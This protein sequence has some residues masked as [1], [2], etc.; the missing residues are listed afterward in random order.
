MYNVLLVDDEPIVKIAL[1]TMIH[2]DELGF[3][4]CG[5]A[6][7]GQEALNLVGKLKP[8]IIITDLKMPN[9][10]GLQF[11]RELNAQNYKGKVIVASN[12]GDYELVREA[13][14]LGAVDYILKIS[15]QTEGLITQ[16]RQTASLL[17]EEQHTLQE[18]EAKDRFLRN[19]LKSVKSS[20]L[21]DYFT[22]THYDIHHF[23]QNKQIVLNLWA[24]PCYLFYITFDFDPADEHRIKGNISASFIEN[25]ILNLIE[26]VNDME[27]FQVEANSII[28][29]IPVQQLIDHHMEPAVFMSKVCKLIEMYISLKPIIVFTKQFVGYDEARR[30]Y[31]ACM[32]ALHIN[33]YNQLS[34]IDVSEVE[35]SLDMGQAN[36]VDYSISVLQQWQKEGK[37]SIKNRLETLAQKCKRNQI[38]PDT[39]KEFIMKCLDYIPLSESKIQVHDAEQYQNHRKSIAICKTMDALLSETWQAFEC[40]TLLSEAPTLPILKKEVQD[41][42]QYIESHYQ[43]K[44]TLE[45]IADHVNFSENYLCRVFK[46][47]VGTSL[48]T[49]I[50]HVRMDKAA[51]LIMQGSTYMKEVA[52]L[53]GISDQFYFNRLFKKQF[54]ISPSEYKSRQLASTRQLASKTNS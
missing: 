37:D 38:H 15:I 44:I 1:R 28:A 18:Q 43:D 51:A 8:D 17:Q 30:K 40:L 49:Y 12:F 32:D 24:T 29:L 14:L 53:V 33:F 27:V 47:Q 13:L 2:W 11:M 23:L 20:I 6:S 34:T 39:V 16:L 36:Y 31:R 10:D 52:S 45:M 35:F 46:E 9:M 50:N 3:P 7:D 4:I 19:N 26:T 21:K 41:V 42:I 54:G 22:D 25:T 48:I 5:T